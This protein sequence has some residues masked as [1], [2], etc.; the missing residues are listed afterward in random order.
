MRKICYI[1]L[2]FTLLVNVSYTASFARIVDPDESVLRW[3]TTSK[4]VT[5]EFG[6]DR[7]HGKHKGIDI[8]PVKSDIAGDSIIS[9]RFGKV[10][11]IGTPKYGRTI[12][13]NHDIRGTGLGVDYVQTVYT[14]LKNSV[15]VTKNQNV[16][17]GQ[18]IAEM[19]NSGNPD[20]NGGFIE[21]GYKVH[22]HYE[23]R[24]IP[25]YDKQYVW[26]EDLPINPLAFYRGGG[27]IINSL[28]QVSM[29]QTN[30]QYSRYLN[31]EVKSNYDYQHGILKGDQLY[32][33]DYLLNMN[34]EEI[35]ASGITSQELNNL[36]NQ[37]RET[38][39]KNY[40]KLIKMIE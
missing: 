23:T 19:G 2:V 21:H 37:I 16:T 12:A 14:H 27:V 18:K 5:D 36:A 40:Y 7:D 3:P 13:I 1:M 28:P 38:D 31:N 33:I 39:S 35:Y 25:N 4:N 22:L 6:T 26:E 11:Y 30:I 24:K 34:M 8:S 15:I 9:A 20:P 10:V 29:N 17:G 32:I